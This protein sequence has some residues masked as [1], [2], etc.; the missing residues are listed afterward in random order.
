MKKVPIRK[1][2][3][4]NEHF[5]KKSLIRVVRTPQGDI[6]LDNTGKQNG[7]GAYVCN[8]QACLSR[9]L[10]KKNLQRVFQCQIEEEVIEKLRAKLNELEA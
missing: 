8:S 4:C 2:I 5:E 9:V 3:A 6:V 1:C 10:S 7:R